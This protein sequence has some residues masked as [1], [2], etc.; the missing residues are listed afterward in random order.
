M[1]ENASTPSEPSAPWRLKAQRFWR[2]TL[3]P[4]LAIVLVLS[5]FRSAV[6]D[7]N[8]V[9][10][11][12]MRPTILVGDRIVVDRRAYDVRV[13][14]TMVSLWR[15]DNPHRGDIIVFISP[16]DGIRLVK[17]VVGTPGDRVE[18]RG[19]ALTINGI[20]AGLRNTG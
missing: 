9:P 3:R 18:L 20:A 4:L 15:Y 10:S 6:A 7:W 11:G 19:F 13:P 16:K 17:R 5:A 1:D 8:D 2:E 12:S 14:F